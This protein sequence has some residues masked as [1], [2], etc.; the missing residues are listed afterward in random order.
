MPRGIYKRT[1][2]KGPKKLSSA[3]ARKLKKAATATLV[4][5]SD[6]N[7]AQIAT[8]IPKEKI[9][10]E[11]PARP[12]RNIVTIIQNRGGNNVT[13]LTGTSELL[14]EVVARLRSHNPDAYRVNVIEVKI[15]STASFSADSEPF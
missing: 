12:Y 3:E 11:A 8:R 9:E 13:N 14:E 7:L 6:L 15:V 5:P 4:D 1:S 10:F 2:R